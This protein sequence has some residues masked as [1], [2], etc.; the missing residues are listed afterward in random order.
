M[1]QLQKSFF[2][3]CKQ[4]PVEH[5]SKIAH[6]KYHLN[7]TVPEK[8]QKHIVNSHRE[9]SA[10]IWFECTQF[11]MNGAFAWASISFAHLFP[12]EDTWFV[13]DDVELI[14]FGEVK[15]VGEHDV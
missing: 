3:T 13:V 8:I 7:Q 9:M 12:D 2:T 14:G 10:F 15:A 1:P 6:A 4:I 5:F 11:D